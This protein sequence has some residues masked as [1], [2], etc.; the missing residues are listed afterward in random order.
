MSRPMVPMTD[1]D[2]EEVVSRGAVNELA[3]EIRRL[4]EQLF[5]AQIAADVAPRTEYA[6][7][8]IYMAKEKVVAAAKE[9]AARH[10]PGGEGDISS[11]RLGCA[12]VAYEDAEKE[13]GCL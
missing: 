4:R 3:S 7:F 9:W 13:W 12:L 6:T 8:E 10:L 5:A 1:F 11:Q 2:L